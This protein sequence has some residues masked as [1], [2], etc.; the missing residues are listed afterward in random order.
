MAVMRGN[1]DDKDG[2]S[3]KV[4]ELIETEEITAMTPTGAV[5]SMWDEWDM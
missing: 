3:E 1:K 2:V 4:V 5:P